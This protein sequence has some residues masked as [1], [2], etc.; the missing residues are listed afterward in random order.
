MNKD[1]QK[2]HAYLFV[3]S[4][5]VTIDELCEQFGWTTNEIE[6][7]L[8]KLGSFLKNTGTEL[9]RH[10]NNVEL[11]ARQSLVK[12]LGSPQKTTEQLSTSAMEV[13]AIIAYRQPITREEIVEIRGINSDQSIK[14]L[15]EKNLIDS[16][17]SKKGGINFTHFKTT[18]QFL[19]H[20]GINSISNLPS[21]GNTDE[22]TN[23]PK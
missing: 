17:V 8:G 22:K 16:V 14:G 23:K 4:S 6:V 18:K 15:L 3:Y 5:G 7:L 11:A 13:L 19:H 2:L 21:L 1:L 20:L 10:N 9:I 12:G